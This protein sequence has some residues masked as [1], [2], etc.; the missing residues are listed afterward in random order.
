MT[1]N[2][3]KYGKEVVYRGINLE[4]VLAM[5]ISWSIHESILWATF[6][7]LLGWIY[8]IYYAFIR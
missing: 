7:G 2:K 6:H 3:H 5:I 8:V 1:N 4:N